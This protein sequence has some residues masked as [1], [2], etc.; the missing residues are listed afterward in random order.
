MI[1]HGLRC[2]WVG[3]QYSILAVFR[4]SDEVGSIKIFIQ[5]LNKDGLYAL[6]G[7]WVVFGIRKVRLL[8]AHECLKIQYCRLS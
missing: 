2:E 5:F 7:L 8:R 1:E 4:I 3:F 6:G